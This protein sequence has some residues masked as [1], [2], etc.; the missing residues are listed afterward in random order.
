MRKVDD[1]NKEVHEG[2]HQFERTLKD[3]YGISTKVHKDDAERAVSES[4]HNSPLKQT[5]KLQRLS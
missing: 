1:A 3:T 4:M 2:I 5:Q